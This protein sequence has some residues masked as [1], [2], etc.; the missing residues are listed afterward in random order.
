MSNK[1]NKEERSKTKM[2]RRGFIGGSLTAFVGAGLAGGNNLFSYDRANPSA[3]PK[4]KGYRTLGR[5]G[6]KVSDIGFGTGELTDPALL[7][8][9]LDAGVNF[10]DTA[11]GYS[12]G[13]TERMIGDVVKK[14]DRKSVFITTKMG[15]SKERSKKIIMCTHH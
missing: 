5:T 10:I 8:G 14:R 11:E 1:G 3:E 7:A 15:L 9:I 2:S 13:Q 4:V 12:R 6:F